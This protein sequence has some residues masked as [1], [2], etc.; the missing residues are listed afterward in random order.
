VSF[1][2]NKGMVI[3]GAARLEVIRCDDEA[4]PE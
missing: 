1:P 2:N 3:D 4:V